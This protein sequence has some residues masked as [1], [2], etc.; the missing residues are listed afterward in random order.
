MLLRIKASVAIFAC[1]LLCSGGAKSQYC[2]LEVPLLDT[3]DYEAVSK[4]YHLRKSM[5]AF[6]SFSSSSKQWSGLYRYVLY[7][8]TYPDAPANECQLECWELAE[9]QGTTYNWNLTFR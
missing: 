2:G 7:Q 6:I 5:F 9:G 4:L 8:G 1:A 3:F